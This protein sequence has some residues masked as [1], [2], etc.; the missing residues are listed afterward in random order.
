MWDA[1]RIHIEEGPFFIGIA[2]GFPMP[3]IA[4]ANLRNIPDFGILGPWAV[5]A[6]G[7]TNPEQYFFQQ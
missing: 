3:A 2:G 4:N 6:P 5:G 7:N 1:I